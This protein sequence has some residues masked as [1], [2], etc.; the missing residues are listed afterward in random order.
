MDRRVKTAIEIMHLEGDR[1]L[2]VREV[3]QRVNLSPW[4][5]TR[6]FK[7]ETA[8]SPKRYVRCLKITK[9]QELLSETFLS[10]KEIAANV[11]FGDRSHF[12]RDFKKMCGKAPSDFRA[13]NIIKSS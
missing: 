7:A 9:A 12:S 4:H 2:Q 13:R 11:G 5:F 8:V 6:L 10:V 1:N 3:A